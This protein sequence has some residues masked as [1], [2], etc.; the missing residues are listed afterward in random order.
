MTVLNLLCFA[1]RYFILE[2]CAASLQ[3]F[4][5]QDY[6]GP[7]PSDVQVLYQLSRGLDYIHSKGLVYCKIKPENILISLTRPVVMKWAD[8]G[9]SK[10][11]QDSNLSGNV[12]SAESVCWMAPEILVQT[13]K[14]EICA[15]SKES[16]IFSAGCV[17]FYFLT[18]AHPFG[19]KSEI[20]KNIMEG[21]PVI[22]ATSI[23]ILF[24]SFCNKLS[25]LSFS[26]NMRQDFQ[27]VASPWLL[28]WE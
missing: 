6:I 14:N 26:L 18:R 10:L 24:G 5:D 12:G 17:Y 15:Y 9:L 16:D 25:S 4:F 7:M 13:N 28:L 11:T 2:Q 8:F 27:N 21:K 20:K 3:G 19:K 22:I 23:H 1:Y